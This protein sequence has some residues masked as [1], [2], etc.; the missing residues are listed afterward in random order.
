MDQLSGYN[1]DDLACLFILIYSI[2][3]TF[4]MIYVLVMYLSVSASVI[5]TY[6]CLNKKIVRHIDYFVLTQ[7]IKD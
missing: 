6:I 1:D 5:F 7:I 2:F 3:D 4:V